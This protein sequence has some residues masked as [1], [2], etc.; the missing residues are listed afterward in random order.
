M[1][2]QKL[3]ELHAIS[4]LRGGRRPFL[5][6][7]GATLGAAVSSH[8]L[9]G[10][11]ETSGAADRFDPSAPWWLQ[12][13]FAPVY[14]EIEAS[15]L[16][17][18]GSIPS[19]LDGRYVRNG[20]NPADAD[21]GHWFFGDGMLHSVRLSGG[22]AM[23]YRNRWVRT[24]RLES[25]D[26]PGR[27]PG[28]GNNTSNVSAVLHAGRLLSSGEVGLPFLI[29]PSDLSTLGVHDFGGELSQSFTAHPKVDPTSGY[30][31]F[32]GYWFFG[33]DLLLYHVADADGNVISTERI[34]VG[35]STMIHSFAIT[36]QD[37]VFWEAPVLF[38]IDAAIAGEAI[39][40]KWDASYGARV[41]VMPLGGPVADI[42]WVEVDP[43]YV[44]HEV[45]AYRDGDDVIVDVCWH[46]DM[47]AGADL[48]GGSAG[49]VVKRWRINTAGENLTHREE[50]IT[51]RLFE[52]P[53][54]DRRFTGRPY[55]YGWFAETRDNPN[56]VDFAGVGQVD[57][58][59]GIVSSWDP[60]AT[61]HAGEAFFV[62]GDRGEGEGWLL[63]FV[64][65]HGAEQTVLAILDARNV[66]AGPIAEV[67]LPQRVPYGFHGVWVPG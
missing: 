33:Q 58:Q 26:M 7:M 3:A 37:V 66:A 34:P 10:C 64:Y 46:P 9:P 38:D 30:M 29:D 49:D 27:T 62:P 61:R 47:F 20:S 24:G 57:Y 44:F 35:A 31:H 65:D 32:F 14:D 42:R 17:V 43:F 6:G 15:D 45:N 4:D 56:T 50:T 36:E 13:N 22:R 2:H 12:G 25:G 16:E 1:S 19:A 59:T 52:L 41:G 51:S 53:S 55:R 39:P 67:I 8:L 60:G 11:S 5:R 54:H 28:G 21:S 63:S 40:F 48:I 23:S 18:R